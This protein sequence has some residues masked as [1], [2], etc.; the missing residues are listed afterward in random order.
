MNSTISHHTNTA[1]FENALNALIENI[2]KAI[3]IYWKQNGFTYA[4]PEKVGVEAVGPKFIRLCKYSNNKGVLTCSSVHCFIN[5]ETG[6]IHKAATF[7]AAD[8]KAVRGNIISPTVLECVTVH[9]TAYLRG[10]S[11]DSVARYLSLPPKV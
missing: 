11:G 6:N 7:K 9:G 3:E 4:D 2:N 8:A 10:G 1:G 5:R